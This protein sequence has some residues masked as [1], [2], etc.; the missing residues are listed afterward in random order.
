MLQRLQEAEG[1]SAL[2]PS[3]ASTP[4]SLSVLSR[5]KNDHGAIGA[6]GPG[7]EEQETK[8]RETMARGMQGQ[9]GEIPD[10]FLQGSRVG[11]SRVPRAG[12]SRG[13]RAA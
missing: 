11:S 4:R 5:G 1:P 3:A 7:S 6:V 10:F 9:D 12:S 2:A 8:G 13:P